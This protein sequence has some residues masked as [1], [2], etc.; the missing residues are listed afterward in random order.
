MVHYTTFE[1]EFKDDIVGVETA[2]QSEGPHDPNDDKIDKQ[3][4]Y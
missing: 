3:N 2:A 1:I 4:G